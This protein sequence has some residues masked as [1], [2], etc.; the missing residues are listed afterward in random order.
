MQVQDV[1]MQGSWPDDVLMLPNCQVDL[2]SSSAMI[3][4]GPRIRMGIC[5]G[6][7]GSTSSKDERGKQ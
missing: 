4:N 5:E 2:D 7:R 3:W 1:L 6:E